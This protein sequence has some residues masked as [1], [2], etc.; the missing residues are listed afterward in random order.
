MTALLH[1]D[2]LATMTEVRGAMYAIIQS[3]GK[4]YRVAEGDR[5]RVERLPQGPG[6]TVELE[7]MLLGGEKVMVGQPTIPEAKVI[8]S[9]TGE[10]KGKKVIVFKYKPKVRY[11]RKNG[12]R[13]LFTELTIEKIQW[14]D[15]EP[16]A[17]EQAG[18]EWPTKKEEAAPVTDGTA[19][20]ND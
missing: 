11:R 18:D 13:Q 7:P 6:S 5:I 20:Q 3:G 9:V 15:G 10:G 14:P 8:A 2:T 1:P 16:Q 19:P 4:Q 17:E 12:H